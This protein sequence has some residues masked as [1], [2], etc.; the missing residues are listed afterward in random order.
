M[1]SF[2]GFTVSKQEYLQEVLSQQIILSQM[3][4]AL[5]AVREG[6]HFVCKLFDAVTPF[7]VALVY[8][9]YLTFNS[10]AVHKPLTSRPAN[11]ERYLICKWKKSKEKVMPILSYLA[12]CHTLLWNL[13]N[14]EKQEPESILELLPSQLFVNCLPFYVYIKASNNK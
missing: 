6:G 7:T 13:S 8:F 9:M 14:E 11:S 2:Q 3:F 12:D 1:I 10:V 5:A 4:V